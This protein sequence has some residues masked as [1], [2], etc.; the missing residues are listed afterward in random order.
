MMIQEHEHTRDGLDDLIDD[1]GKPHITESFIQSL[2][3]EVNEAGFD[4]VQV[5]GPVIFGAFDASTTQVMKRSV[6]SSAF[7]VLRKET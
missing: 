4:R 7:R 3:V 6:A 1:P 5:A 2:L